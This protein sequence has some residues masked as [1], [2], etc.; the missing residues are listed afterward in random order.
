MSDGFGEHDAT[1]PLGPSR[2]VRGLGTRIVSSV[3]LVA[4]GFVFTILYLAFLAQ[5]F[6]WYQNLAV[7]AAVAIVV[8][9]GLAV[10]WVLWAMG[11]ARRAG[12]P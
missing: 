2:F 4:G 9:A 12:L 3:A 8:P 11:F 6:A 5:R 1:W 7:V 10:T